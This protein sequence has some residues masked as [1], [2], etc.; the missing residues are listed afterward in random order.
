MSESIIKIETESNPK[1]D[2]SESANLPLLEYGDRS[3]SSR[4]ASPSPPAIDVESPLAILLAKQCEGKNRAQKVKILEKAVEHGNLFLDN[5][6]QILAQP[7]F[8]SDFPACKT[9]NDEIGMN[10]YLAPCF[11]SLPN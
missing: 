5:I 7:Q 6:S 2:E 10:L 1:M 4:E 3:S 9:R 11:P 8:A